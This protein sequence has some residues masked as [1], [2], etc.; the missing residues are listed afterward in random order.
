M[1]NYTHLIYDINCFEDTFK[2][3]KYMK[4]MWKCNDASENK[5]LELI[6][7]SRDSDARN[8]RI[9]SKQDLGSHNTE[10]FM[11]FM[12]L[13]VSSYIY[14]PFVDKNNKNYQPQT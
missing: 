13:K 5:P 11:Q 1:R 10:L 6:M 9:E 4:R 12:E 14:S 2:G 8:E 3:A 7:M